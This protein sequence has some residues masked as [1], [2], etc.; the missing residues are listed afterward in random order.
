MAAWRFGLSRRYAVMGAPGGNDVADVS[1]PSKLRV[2]WRVGAV[3]H[4]WDALGRAQ[5]GAGGRGH[6]YSRARRA[7]GCTA[8]VLG[9]GRL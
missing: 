6:R 2:F 8:Q 1:V 9:I 3:T 7:A 5:Q 4:G